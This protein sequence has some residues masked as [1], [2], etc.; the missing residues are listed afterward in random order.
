MTDSTVP[1]DTGTRPRGG[2]TEPYEPVHVLR[3]GVGSS[4]ASGASGSSSEADPAA[5]EP[6]P[7]DRFADPSLEATPYL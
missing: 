7:S 3:W 4:S 1:A 5:L 2:A 6:L